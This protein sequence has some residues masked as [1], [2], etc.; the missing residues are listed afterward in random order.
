MS[1][2]SS[3][4]TWGLKKPIIELFFN[5]LLEQFVNKGLG[6]AWQFVVNIIHEIQKM[7]ICNSKQVNLGA[8]RIKEHSVKTFDE[9]S[10]DRAGPKTTRGVQLSKMKMCQ[11]MKEDLK[12]HCLH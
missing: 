8:T 10:N 2:I 5:K 3:N 11:K 4:N 9:L 1:W 7:T 12:P 6:N